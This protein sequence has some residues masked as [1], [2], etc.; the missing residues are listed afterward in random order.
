MIPV[1]S[2]SAPIT[3]IDPPSDQ[4][5]RLRSVLSS[6][7]WMRWKTHA[8]IRDVTRRSL[9]EGVEVF[10]IENLPDEALLSI[11]APSTADNVFD[12]IVIVRPYLG[13]Y[14]SVRASQGLPIPPGLDRA[15]SPVDPKELM[16]VAKGITTL[17]CGEMLRRKKWLSPPA[18]SGDTFPDLG[19]INLGEPLVDPSLI[20]EAYPDSPLMRVIAE[21]IAEAW[22][23]TSSTQLGERVAVLHESP[24]LGACIEFADRAVPSPGGPDLI[25]RLLGAMGLAHQV[26]SRGAYP[27]AVTQSCYNIIHDSAIKAQKQAAE[28]AP[29]PACGAWCQAGIEPER[30]LAGVAYAQLLAQALNAEFEARA[31]LRQ[32]DLPLVAALIFRRIVEGEANY[33]ASHLLIAQIHDALDP[34]VSGVATQRP[35]HSPGPASV[36]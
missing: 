1:G 23:K 17:C 35:N 32:E 3:L 19:N 6:S 22:P 26:L 30:M 8:W 21:T 7:E 18:M 14:A 29:V 31:E 13:A 5:K 11:Y 34:L 33:V 12:A 25:S 27:A 10:L 2:K 24:A 16:T 20:L 9:T 15:L 28:E 4:F 36:H